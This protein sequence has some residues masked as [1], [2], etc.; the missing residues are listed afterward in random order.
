MWEGYPF[1]SLPDLS[2]PGMVWVRATTLP[3]RLHA[4]R[5]LPDDLFFSRDSHYPVP[6]TCWTGMDVDK[7]RGIS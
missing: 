5:W 3:V 1:T 4:D 6:D 2:P 7:I